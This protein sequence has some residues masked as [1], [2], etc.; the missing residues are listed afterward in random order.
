MRKSLLT[1]TVI[2]ALA[3][4]GAPGFTAENP[5]HP[6]VEYYAAMP[7]GMSGVAAQGT[8]FGSYL[9]NEPSATIQSGCNSAQSAKDVAVARNRCE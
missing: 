4:G 2:V 6:R 9:T 7:N 3:S 5:Q 1:V 8:F